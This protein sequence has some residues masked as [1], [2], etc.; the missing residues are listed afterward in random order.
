MRST[1]LRLVFREQHTRRLGRLISF[2]FSRKFLPALK[3]TQSFNMVKSTE[4][5]TTLRIIVVTT[6]VLGLATTLHAMFVIPVIRQ[7]ARDILDKHNETI[8]PGSVTREDV[9]SLREDIRILRVEMNSRFD[10]LVR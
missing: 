2:E 9:K 6:A 10:T 8:H 1:L 4:R 7:E 5:V 3:S